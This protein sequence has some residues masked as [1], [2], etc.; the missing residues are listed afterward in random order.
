MS[1]L[2]LS[3]PPDLAVFG[4]KRRQIAVDQCA[5]RALAGCFPARVEGWS[6]DSR[7]NCS[8]ECEDGR[9]GADTVP[10]RP[11]DLPT[12]SLG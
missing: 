12:P 4:K 9:E 3:E 11:R 1:I 10:T 8:W 2:D 6:V 5:R 7:G